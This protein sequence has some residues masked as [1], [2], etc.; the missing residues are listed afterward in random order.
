MMNPTRGSVPYAYAIM[1]CRS[2][3]SWQAIPA[4]ADHKSCHSRATAV[5]E[6]GC[7]ACAV[8][9]VMVHHLF[10]DLA[11]VG[12]HFV[13]TREILFDERRNIGKFFDIRRQRLRQ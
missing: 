8:A 2:T 3:C 6:Y 7:T 5:L 9:P 11:C 13:D 10:V 1:R 4:I 12:V